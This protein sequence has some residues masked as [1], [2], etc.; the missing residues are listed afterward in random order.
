MRNKIMDIHNHTT[1]SDGV[2]T[3]EEIIENG[4]SNK[5]DIIGISDHFNTNK[6]NSISISRLDKYIKRLW[7][8]KEKYKD[9]IEVL[10]G[11]EICM[12][13]EWSE[14]EIL[15]YE[16]LNKLDYVLFEYIDWFSDSVTLNEIEYYANRFTCKKGLA[17]TNIFSLIKKY[18]VN[19]VIRIINKNRLFWELNVNEGYEYFDYIITNKDALDVIELFNKLKENKIKITVG[20]DT[21]S[22]KFYDIK[23]IMIGN[24]LAALCD[25]TK[26]NGN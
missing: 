4:I 13:K 8:I 22:L 11:I 21:H 14:L 10:A 3:M 17:H 1:W 23:K 18:G 25:I 5:V 7:K 2:H 20:S 15:P 24:E 6:C 9:K 19:N 16:I 26:V 12:N